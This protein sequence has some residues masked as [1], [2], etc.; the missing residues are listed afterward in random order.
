MSNHHF[1]F[2]FF[3]LVHCSPFSFDRLI[4][5]HPDG[6]WVPKG[7]FGIHL[8]FETQQSTVQRLPKVLCVRLLR[9]QFWIDVVQITVKCPVWLGADDGVVHAVEEI[10]GVV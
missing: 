5:V 1:L 10:N 8:L 2:F 9:G 3:F 4:S 7:L 6:L